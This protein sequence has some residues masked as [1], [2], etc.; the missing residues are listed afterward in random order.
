VPSSAAV[1]RFF[2][3]GKDIFRAKRATLSDNIFDILMFMKGN[4]HHL[5]SLDLSREA[6]QVEEAEIAEG[7][8]S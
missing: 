8:G 2:S 7:S 4:S 5:A 3:L 6:A 1:E